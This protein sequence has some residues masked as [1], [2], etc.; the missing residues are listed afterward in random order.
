MEK[1]IFLFILSIELA[2]FTIAQ[3]ERVCVKNKIFE[4]N[5][6]S[7]PVDEDYS[8]SYF[9]YLI[10]N[11]N[12]VLE[13]S[14]DYPESFRIS[15]YAFAEHIY[16]GDISIPDDLR[17]EGKSIVFYE[18]GGENNFF[19]A[20][21]ECSNSHLFIQRPP[22]FIPQD[23]LSNYDAY[24]A[25]AKESQKRNRDLFTEFLYVKVKSPCEPQLD[26]F[27]DIDG[28]KVGYLIEGDLA[29]VLETQGEWSKVRYLKTG[30]EYWTYASCLK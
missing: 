7:E 22:D 2:G 12:E 5:H 17:E 8:N 29:E 26:V 1:I 10:F 6:I 16:R 14:P 18:E 25:I 9:N 3:T 23:R 28:T 19:A 11:E 21:V 24:V 27:N 30:M 20:Y 4:S 13:F 15:R